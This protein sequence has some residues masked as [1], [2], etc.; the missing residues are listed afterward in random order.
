MSVRRLLA[1]IGLFAVFAA[2]A[3]SDVKTFNIAAQSLAKALIA[4][5]E[6]SNVVVM[7]PASLIEG[8]VAPSVVGEMQPQKALQKLL[9]GSGL[10]SRVDEK[11]TVLIRSASKTATTGAGEQLRLVSRDTFADAQT[12]A[13]PEAPEQ[14][15][16]D[17]ADGK[18]VPEILVKGKRSVNVDIQRTEDDVQ[19]YVVFDSK[20]IERSLSSN[21]EDF[22]KRQLPMNMSFASNSQQGETA[23]NVSTIDLRGLGT[24]ETLILVNGRR[25]PG[26]SQIAGSGDIGQPDINGIPLSAIERVEVLPSTAA[27]IYGGGANGG[28][29]NI[30]MKSDFNQ[31]EIN[32]NYDNS[33]DTD[34]GYRRMDLTAG[35]NLES[36]RTNVLLTGSY[37]DS[38]EM[39]IGDRPFVEKARALYYRPGGPTNGEYPFA[40]IVPLGSTTNIRAAEDSSNGGYY[41]LLLANP[42]G[43]APIQLGT[44]KTFVPLGYA[45]IQSDG[46]AALIANA[47]ANP[48]KFNLEMPRDVQGSQAGIL[49]N[50]VVTSF[51]MNLRRRFT[52][53]IEGFMDLSWNHNEGHV[54]EASDFTEL[55]LCPKSVPNDDCVG[56]VGGVPS[57]LFSPGNPFEVPVTI[58]FPTPGLSFDRV[59][60]SENRMANGGFIVRLPRD[61]VAQIEY[62]WSRSRTEG[63]DTSPFI[64]EAGQAAIDA[65]VLDVF[66]D[67]NIYTPDYDAVN[68]TLPSPN[69]FV[70]PLDNTRTGAT[71]RIAG[72]VF[73]LPGGPLSASVFAERRNSDLA[74]GTL[75]QLTNVTVYP[76]RDETVDSVSTEISVPLFSKRNRRSW[77]SALELQASVRH[78]RYQI[79]G[80]ET[81]GQYSMDADGNFLIQNPRFVN[82]ITRQ[83][84]PVTYRPLGFSTIDMNST[85]YTLGFRYAPTEDVAVR[86]SFGTGFRPPNVAQ[87]SPTEMAVEARNLI[88]PKRQPVSGPQNRESYLKYLPRGVVPAGTVLQTIAQI[89]G[90]GP[91]IRAELSESISAGVVLTPR[92]LPGL[93]LSLDFTDIEKTDE[94][95]Q[96]RN[97]FSNLQALIQRPTGGGLSIED[98]IPG[99][100]TRAPLTAADQARGYTAGLISSYK[101]GLVNASRASVRSFDTQVDYRF[102]TSLGEVRAYALA[103]YLKNYTNQVLETSPAYDNAGFAFRL[104]WRGN[105]GLTLTRKAWTMDWNMQYYDSYYVYTASTALFTP[106]G[107]TPQEAIV[108]GSHTIPHQIYHD[109]TAQF[110]LGE[111]LG[112]NQGWFA[113]T[114]LTIGIRNVLDTEPPI[115]ATFS[116]AVG[117]SWYGDPR[118]RRYS[119]SLRKSFH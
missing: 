111:A 118:M 76:P 41:E 60:L 90:G 93:R 20:D 58:A 113:G 114:D 52:P 69:R 101:F 63:T 42:A 96:Y 6:Q 26:V 28:V 62:S 81:G 77:V 32:T 67:L 3:G 80:P 75:R 24:D 66:R 34:S 35:F 55:G 25:L 23:G 61:W 22:L 56:L 82:P 84:D 105:A 94:I 109:L 54:I 30:I 31:I 98:Q 37:S 68:F 8:K 43:G 12:V 86:A 14:A 100:V 119:I 85:D 40:D 9:K 71:F 72:P 38:N 17:S 65:G 117:Y 5:S 19:P 108:Q 97:L 45:G 59:F 15:P 115:A 10:E 87:A 48:N 49:N 13:G 104:K 79:H 74:F 92:F 88:D 64:S 99:L 95:T 50:P 116:P 73:D 11:G 21:L 27:G 78:D 51:G 83:Q 112:V 4:F 57:Y 91:D 89:G 46:G 53:R 106:P 18:G 36:G 70:G 107:A 39:V 103:T 110:R 7:A 33:F 47:L 1:L 29:I 44:S 102:D 2:H 16:G